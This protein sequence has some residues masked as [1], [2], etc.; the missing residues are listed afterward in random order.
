MRKQS[1][2]TNEG[3][4]EERTDHL[5]FYRFEKRGC[6][7]SQL[8]SNNKVPEYYKPDCPGRLPSA[9]T[10][11]KR[12]VR[13]APKCSNLERENRPGRKLVG[14]LRRPRRSSRSR[15]HVL[16]NAGRGTLPQPKQRWRLTECCCR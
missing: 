11:N 7:L 16:N 13:H 6:P 4:G 8:R 15:G 2:Q 10:M 14:Y 3:A 9:S 1:Q 5:G 12:L